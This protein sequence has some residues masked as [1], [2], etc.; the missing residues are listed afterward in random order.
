LTVF[1]GFPEGYDAARSKTDCVMNVVGY[2]YPGSQVGEF[3]AAANVYPRSFLD[4]K[5]GFGFF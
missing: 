4:T 3:G 2:S 1:P 5:F